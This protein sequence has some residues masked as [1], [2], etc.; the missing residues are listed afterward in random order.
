MRAARPDLKI[1]LRDDVIGRQ[2]IA[3]GLPR[4]TATGEMPYHRWARME[5]NR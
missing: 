3:S 4:I 5:S 1:A 2:D